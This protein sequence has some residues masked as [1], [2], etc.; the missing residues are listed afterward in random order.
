MVKL[1]FTIREYKRDAL[2]IVEA[3]TEREAFV[4]ARA[5][6]KEH[7]CG[8]LRTLKIL[9]EIDETETDGVSLVD[10]TNNS[11][12]YDLAVVKDTA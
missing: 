4:K 11:G 3:N 2:Y 5:H 7:L 9:G 12:G 6:A 10:P 1:L 8:D